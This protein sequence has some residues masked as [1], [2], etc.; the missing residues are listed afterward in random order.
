MQDNKSSYLASM[1]APK[2]SYST[3]Q[4]T[5]TQTGGNYGGYSTP[6]QQYAASVLDYHDKHNITGGSVG[7][8]S[9]GYHQYLG[10]DDH[11][12]QIYRTTYQEGTSGYSPTGLLKI[13]GPGKLTHTDEDGNVIFEE[14]SMYRSVYD[15][16]FKT[17]GGPGGSGNPYGYYGGYGPGYSSGI[18]GFGVN[19]LAFFRGRGRG[20]DLGT[21]MLDPDAVGI[22]AARAG[23]DLFSMYSQG[24]KPFAIDPKTDGILTM[25]TA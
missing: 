20:K 13:G 8:G 3:P 11:N 1:Y 19:P 17:T 9:S 16:N 15:P 4:V 21:T 22:Q 7:L 14:G 24:I 25:L 5:Q 2:P 18:A 23:S 12:N 6:Q 10:K